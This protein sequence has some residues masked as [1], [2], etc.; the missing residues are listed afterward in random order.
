MSAP[1]YITKNDNLLH[2]PSNLA[3]CISTHDGDKLI[4]TIDWIDLVLYIQG[5]SY[6]HVGML[7]PFYGTSTKH[8]GYHDFRN[9]LWI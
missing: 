8:K 2:K 1:V 9:E 7:P 6:G 3:I 4:V 5:N